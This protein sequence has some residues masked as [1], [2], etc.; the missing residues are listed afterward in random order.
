MKTQFYTLPEWDFV[1]GET[2]KRMITLRKEG[3]DQYDLPGATA[4]FAIAD[5]VN[6][7]STPLLA[8][9][10]QITEDADGRY[11]VV[12]IFLLPSETVD[13]FGKHVYQITVKDASGNVTIPQKGIMHIAYNIDRTFIS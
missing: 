5:F 6:P 8:K 9:D 3:G 2:Q 11:C 10:I 13:L 12:T 4:H 1:G 7:G